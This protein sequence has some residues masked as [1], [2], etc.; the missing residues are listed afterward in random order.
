MLKKKRLI[1]APRQ[2]FRAPPK[3]TFGV[4][5]LSLPRLSPAIFKILNSMAM[6]STKTPDIG[7]LSP[8]FKKVASAKNT[9]NNSTPAKST[10]LGK[11]TNN[12]PATPAT[13]GGRRR[14]KKNRG[15]RNKSKK[16]GEA[17]VE[18]LETGPTVVPEGK[19]SKK[20][21][22]QERGTKELPRGDGKDGVVVPRPN[23][24]L[25]P[26]LGGRFLQLDPVFA[27]NEKYED[28]FLKYVG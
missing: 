12:V 21:S 4:G 8:K 19:E 16:L 6:P 22:K 18:G 26:S 1:P 11:S 27:K 25:S 5:F 7:A 20:K 15:P 17:K 23:W 2:D 14:Q 10:P 28:L 24:K 13:G 3:K 9:P